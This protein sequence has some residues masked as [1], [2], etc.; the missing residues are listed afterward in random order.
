MTG[1]FDNWSK[2]EQ[3]EKVGNGFEKTVK[4][5]DASEKILYKV[6]HQLDLRRTPP[7]LKLLFSPCVSTCTGSL[8]LPGP[9]WSFCLE[10]DNATAGARLLKRR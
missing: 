9:T 6:G 1:T 7:P 5:P 2:S 8:P 4:L 3:L 10:A